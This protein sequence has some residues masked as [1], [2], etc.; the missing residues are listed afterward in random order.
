MSEAGSFS[1]LPSL[2]AMVFRVASCLASSPECQIREKKAS[3]ALAISAWFSR[4]LS[5]SA[6]ACDAERFDCSEFH[7]KVTELALAHTESP[8]VTWR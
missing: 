2:S 4:V 3:M 1:P 6:L 5:S 8:C 7:K